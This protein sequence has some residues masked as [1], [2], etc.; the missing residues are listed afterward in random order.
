MINFNIRLIIGNFRDF[1][2]RNIDRRDVTLVNFVG[3]WY[4]M[5]DNRLEVTFIN[6]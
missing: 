6:L 3:C 5:K 1:V 4:F 2:V